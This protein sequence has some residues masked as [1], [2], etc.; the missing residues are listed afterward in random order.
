[1]KNTLIPLLSIAILVATGCREIE[2]GI[3]DPSCH[4]ASKLARVHV[5]FS[6]IEMGASESTKS[7][8][9][10]DI[11]YFSDAYLFA[12]QASGAGAGN[13]CTVNGVPAAIHTQSKSFDWTLP[14]D[15]PVE[16]LAVVNAADDIR[17][18]LDA[19]AGGQGRYTKANLAALQFSCQ[20]AEDL[21]DLD[22]MP[23]T[24]AVTVTL[25]PDAP[26]MSIPVKRLFAKFNITLDVSDWALQ[27]WTV[28]AAGVTGARSNTQ[29]PYFYTGT[30][31]GFKQTDPV[32]LAAV[33]SSTGA[34]IA[35]LNFRDSGGRSRSVTYY[36]LENCQG[37]QGSADR[38][39]SV[40]LDL[41]SQVQNC[42]YLKVNVA[43]TKPGYGL[44]RFGYRI[45]LDST[46]GSAMKTGFN[47][48]RNTFRSIVLKLGVPQDGFLWTN[49]APISSTPG[50]TVSIPFETTLENNE[51]AFLPQNDRLV[52]QSHSFHENTEHLTSFP[53]C[54]T[55]VFKAADDAP[56]GSYT[57]RGGNSTGDISDMATV[58]IIS[59]INITTTVAE[60]HYAF[61]RFAVTCSSE[62]MEGMGDFQK[63]R[64]EAAFSN[65]GLQGLTADV[66]IIAAN[67]TYRTSVNGTQDVVN[68]QFVVLATRDGVADFKL[69]NTSTGAEYDS[70]N[71]SIAR[72]TIRFVQSTSGPYANNGFSGFD[73]GADEGP[74]Y[75][76]PFTGEEVKGYFQFTD[77]L[78]SA[79]SIQDQDLA[80][81]SLELT[82]ESGF[83]FSV[84]SASGIAR[85]YEMSAY[86]ENWSRL[87]EKGFHSNVDGT[88][89]FIS[90]TFSPSIELRSESGVLVCSNPVH[91]KV[92]NPF[93]EWFPGGDFTP[94]TYEIVLDGTSDYITTQDFSYHWPY[95][96]SNQ[97]TVLSYG[98]VRT[99]KGSFAP[100]SFVYEDNPHEVER[101]R[102]ANDLRN[103]GAIQIGGTITHSRTSDS[104]TMLWGNVDVIR[105]YIIYAGYQFSQVSY[106]SSFTTPYN[107]GN[108]SRFIP[109]IFVL[110]KTGMPVTLRYCVRTT[111][112]A[113][114]GINAVNPSENF[115]RETCAAEHWWHDGN[116]YVNGATDHSGGT[117]WDCEYSLDARQC[118]TQNQVVVY[119]SPKTVTSKGELSYYELQ[120]AGPRVETKI[121]GS[122]GHNGFHADF[123]YSFRNV[124]YWNQPEFEFSTASINPMNNPSIKT[125]PDGETYL[126]LGDYTRIRFFWRMKKSTMNKLNSYD[127]RYAIS[128]SQVFQTTY[129]SPGDPSYYMYY[130][131]AAMHKQTYTATAY[132]DP[133]RD[134]REKLKLYTPSIPF[135]RLSGNTV[136]AAF[137]GT[138]PASSKEEDIVNTHRIGQAYGDTDSFW[139]PENQIQ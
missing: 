26:S 80:L 16:V 86:L 20:S 45:Y 118:L 14:A 102:V 33:D 7:V 18:Q 30:G 109:Y 132:Y 49:T 95:L 15:T 62:S 42:S 22:N 60:S 53:S 103:Y 89:T 59:P 51:L 98:N 138:A 116:N 124:A 108:L 1:M 121:I 6:S 12:F 126:A 70:F 83:T 139:L 67:P 38:W 34:D 27:G 77:A 106:L 5:G 75:H 37:V 92:T 23:M 56:D 73:T 115:Y 85:T 65:L 93:C 48:I 82:T 125:F 3:K 111:A 28:T 128:V 72:P 99:S 81:G 69:Y 25:D 119:S 94:H 24:G 97:P 130:F 134:I 137:D 91:F 11:E 114:T 39:S 105:D 50:G 131:G 64:I 78:G 32:K 88:C 76:T 66:R 129:N 79:I 44:R 117:L 57:I 123:V 90:E 9:S 100:Y 84:R 17:Q 112:S 68:R 63:E 40:A 2:S 61:Q 74:I 47:I 120:Y 10:D 113:K 43:A 8:A 31:A 52:Y 35:E 21:A 101:L 135:Y 54:G 122:Q 41:G 133:R 71:I 29:V 4:G 19:W 13:P 58:Q 87:E 104:V 55:A 107:N 46:E 127:T 110:D 96:A 36:F 136:H